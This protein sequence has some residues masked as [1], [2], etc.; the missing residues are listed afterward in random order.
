MDLKKTTK[1]IE[2]QKALAVLDQAWSYYQPEKP[3]K[4]TD[5]EPELFQYHSAA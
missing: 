2:A 4:L 3:V 1:S 5:Q